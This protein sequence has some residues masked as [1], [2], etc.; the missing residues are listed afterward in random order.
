M[1]RWFLNL[2]IVGALITLVPLAMV[3][4]ERLTPRGD[5]TRLSVFPDMDKTARYSA[6]EPS[7]FF[8]D[9]R[10]ARP[11][12]AGTVAR[13]ALMADDHLHRG[14]VD[15]E[16]ADS[17]PM[18]LDGRQLERGRDRYDVFCAPCHGY[19]GH[20][21]GM[22]HQRALALGEPAWTPPTDLHS[23]IVRERPV[24]HLYNTIAEGIRNMPAYGP[25]LTP[26]DRWAVVAY[27]KALQLSQ[28]ASIEDVPAGKR[29][30]LR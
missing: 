24:G 16:W 11:E 22:V 17:Y 18:T 29:D 1:P 4:K 5:R 7:S 21:D 8:A 6:Q 2:M 19:S 9:G 20:G 12:P 30:L 14:Q 27:V 28:N 10:S 23:E 15:G 3:A 13:G 26:S 25:Q